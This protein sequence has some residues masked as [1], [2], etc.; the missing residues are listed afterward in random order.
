MESGLQKV[1]DSKKSNQ[2]NDTRAC[3]EKQEAGNNESNGEK[4]SEI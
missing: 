2:A 1:Q 4:V 3:A